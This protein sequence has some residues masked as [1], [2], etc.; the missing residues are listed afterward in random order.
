VCVA[1]WRP[2]AVL[3]RGGLAAEQF[4]LLAEGLVRPRRGQ[5]VDWKAKFESD[6]ETQ[7]CVRRRIIIMIRTEAVTEILLRFYSFH[8]RFSSYETKASEHG[9]SIQDDT[10]VP[11][12]AQ[13]VT[14]D[15]LP[16]VHEAVCEAVSQLRADGSQGRRLQSYLELP[17]QIPLV[18]GL[19]EGVGGMVCSA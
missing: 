16:Q 3:G 5:V 17:L 15:V 11:P 9:A 6:E 10:P 2:A 7:Q 18:L 4:Q 13:L 19:P 14:C 12:L 8:L 1:G